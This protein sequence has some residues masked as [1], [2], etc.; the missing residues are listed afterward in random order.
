MTLTE[1]VDATRGY[2][3]ANGVKPKGTGTI[4]DNRLEEM[5][6]VGF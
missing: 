4:S 5:G 3:E 2:A 1:F 6:I